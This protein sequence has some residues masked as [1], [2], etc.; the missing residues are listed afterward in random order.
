MAINGTENNA[1][2]EY[3]LKV[4]LKPYVK[5]IDEEAYYAEDYL[6]GLGASGYFQSGPN[7]MT[8]VLKKEARIVE[9]TSKV[10]MTTGF[11][12]WC[13]YASLTYLR[14]TGNDWLRNEILPLLENGEKL[15]G[16][17]LSNPM[18]YYA[19]LEKLH[20]RAERVE[21]G[22]IFSG[23]LAAVSNLGPDHWFGAI[24]ALNDDRRIMALV[25]CNAEGLVLMPKV[26]YIGLN[27]SATYSCLFQDVFIPDTWVISDDADTYV[28]KVRPSFIVYQ[29]PLGL[30][31]IEASMKAIEQAQNKQCG[32]NTYLQVQ[33]DD[34]EKEWKPLRDRF[35]KL[36]ESGISEESWEPL[37]AI[38]LESAYLTLKAVQVCMLHQGG[39]A[40][41]K[42]SDASRRLREAYF[43]ANLTPTVRHLEKMLQGC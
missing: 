26:E 27:G 14:H 38:R 43:Y 41:L 35:Y 12:L 18:K 10:C 25:S 1:Q 20:L 8:D 32:C 31:V 9:E 24:A 4:K 21:G 36:I 11:N 29:I 7:L 34:I 6:V 22:Y 28:R 40:Y 33:A 19:G 16:S 37:L 5:K 42:H 39:A 15:G 13:H 2:F 30:G 3:L 23:Q 17:G